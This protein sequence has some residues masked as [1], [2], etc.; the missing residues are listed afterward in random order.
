MSLK[1]YCYCD[2]NPRF[3]SNFLMLDEVHTCIRSRGYW[4]LDTE[5][6]SREGMGGEVSLPAADFKWKLQGWTVK[7]KVWS[8]CINFKLSTNFLKTHYNI[9]EL[10]P[11]QKIALAVEEVCQSWKSLRP[12]LAGIRRRP[13]DDRCRKQEGS[14]EAAHRCFSEIFYNMPGSPNIH[15]EY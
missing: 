3:M 6:W 14:S 13:C 10:S 15:E 7:V 4:R 8:D 1:V 11:C 5:L 9:A 12:V 2:F